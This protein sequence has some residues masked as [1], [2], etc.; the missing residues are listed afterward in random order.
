[1]KPLGKKISKEESDLMCNAYQS[2]HPDKT[3]SVLFD[4]D[5]IKQVISAKGTKGLRIHFATNED[6]TDTVVLA[7][8]G[9]DGFTLMDDPTNR[10]QLCPPC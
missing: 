5:T 4:I 9:D 6:G 2:K 10:G 8:V 1:M 7:P 3:H